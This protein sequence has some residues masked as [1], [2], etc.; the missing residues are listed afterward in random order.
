MR[1]LVALQVIGHPRD[2]KRIAML[3]AAGFE[4]EAVAFERKFHKGRMPTCFVRVLGRV[5][6]GHY[7]KRLGT[8]LSA[9]SMF[10]RAIKENDLVYASG[11]D[12]AALGIVAGLWLGRPFALE[13]G[14]IR[15][16]QTAKGLLGWLVR[17]IDRRIANSCCLI[18]ATARG[19]VDDYYRQ[20][21]NV[22]TRS[23]VIENKLD[24]PVGDDTPA[25]FAPYANGERPILD[26]PLRIGYFG[27]LRWSSSWDL[28]RE[29]AVALSE[30]IEIIIA[31]HIIEPAD[32]EGKIEE[33]SNV[34]YLGEFRS[35]DDLPDLFSSVDL[36]WAVYPEIGP[37]DWNLRW[38]RTNRF[39]ESCY[40]NTPLI[41]R[42]GCE[43][44][45]E[46]QRLGIGLSIDSS[47]PRDIIRGI[48]DISF[49]MLSQWRLNMS[50]LPASTYIYTT[51]GAEL[52]QALRDAIS[53]C[54]R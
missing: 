6:H 25:G 11:V 5:E 14:D 24:L 37:N 50:A 47:E 4:V 8:M 53:S 42:A 33:V 15:E 54:S 20:W 30:R 45:R 40:F 27:L 18:V 23:M 36:V 32:L 49:E 21:L 48:E 17:R 26:R 35:P 13:V 39:Y 46:V 1:I 19:F 31:G 22:G 2:S 12:M 34:R 9:I 51:E 41:S 52:A 3:Q 43:D 29:L 7:L 10:R 44:A 38:A 16:I 28:L